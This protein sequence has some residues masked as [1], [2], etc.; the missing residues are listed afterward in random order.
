VADLTP[1]KPSAQK[2]KKD[3][4]GD[5]IELIRTEDILKNLGTM[6]GDKILVGFA[7][8][9]QDLNKNA[10]SKL[11][12]KNL[13]MIVANDVSRKDAGFAVDT[14][15]VRIFERDGSEEQ[16]PIMKKDEIA[17]TILDRVAKLWKKTN[18]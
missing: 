6:K 18:R 1:K 4:Y 13:D 16:L 11:E 5:T 10:K 9:T 12:K 3:E 17:D 2:L 14:N 8:E 7:A 15:I